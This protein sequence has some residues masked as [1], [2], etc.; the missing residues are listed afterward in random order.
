[1]VWLNYVEPFEAEVVREI[2]RYDDIDYIQGNDE[3]YG[4]AGNDILHGQRGDDFISGGDGE[5]ELYG[6]L[7]SDTL[8]GGP[9]NDVIVSYARESLL[10]FHLASR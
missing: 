1:M 4:G 9:G 2:R 6:E 5:D 10:R 8:D 3:I 7:G